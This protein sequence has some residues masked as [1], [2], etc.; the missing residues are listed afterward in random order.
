MLATLLVS[1]ASLATAQVNRR[2]TSSSDIRRPQPNATPEPRPQILE[3]R[4]RGGGLQINVTRGEMRQFDLYMNMT[5]R[6]KPAGEAA[7]VSGQTLAPGECAL[8]DRALFPSEPMEMRAEIINFG[9]RNRQMHGDPV[10]RGD[11]AARRYPDALNVPPYLSNPDHYWV[12]FAFNTFDGY[13]RVTNQHYWQPLTSFGSPGHLKDRLEVGARADSGNKAGRFKN[14]S[15]L[16]VVAT[17]NSDTNPIPANAIRVHVRYRKEYGYLYNSDAFGRQGPWSCDAFNVDTAVLAGAP[18]AFAS[19]KSV[20]NSIITHSPMRL[21]SGYYVCDYT[22]TGLPLNQAIT[23]RGG[24]VGGSQIL[25]GPWLGGSQP[26]PPAGS[27]RS[28]LNAMQSVAL[29]PS[30]SYGIVTFEMVYAPIAA[31]P[32]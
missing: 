29:T 17:M 30:I 4:C 16:G 21:E 18:G 5:V 26:Q 11:E 1:C 9:Q 25:T 23:V 10:Y 6:F 19:Y 12:F 3:L 14:T 28:I 24:M 8:T 13:F 32:R 7:G 15:D 2:V 20:G 22:V 31:P 27:E